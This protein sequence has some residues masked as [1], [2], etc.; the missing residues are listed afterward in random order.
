MSAVATM[1]VRERLQAC[2]H[3][4]TPDR[5][6]LVEWAN[7]WQMTL[8]RWHGEG[9]DQS[10]DRYGIAKYFGLDD[11]RQSW[12]RM[13]PTSPLPARHGAGIVVDQDDYERLR[14]H[15]YPEPAR[16]LADLQAWAP[17]QR[18]GTVGLWLTID[19]CFWFPRTLLGIEP[20][21]YAFY[22][23][24]ELLHR[25][26]QDLCDHVLQWI[27]RLCAICTP[28]FC[29]VAEDI[30]GNTGPMISQELFDEFLLPYYARLL[31]EL[32]SR[33]IVPVVDSD[34][35]VAT[36]LPWFER[37]GFAGILPLERAAGSNIAQLRR[38]HPQAVLIGGFDKRVMDRG[39]D[40]IRAEFARLAPVAASGRCIISCDHQTPPQVGLAD[41][42]VYLDEF[43]RFAGG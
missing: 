27:D 20:H 22:D 24:P 43:R 11:W 17:L 26:C 1:S 16:V 40:A 30:A 41:Y 25:I 37:A 36:C 33:G 31:P 19:G 9:L 39:R 32:R 7:W 4:R 38:D 10:L 21:L 13:T 3:G 23:Q 34:G 35:D 28:D 2:L 42:R 12:W 29:T 15:L 14:P 8:Q 5:L 6:P 18:A